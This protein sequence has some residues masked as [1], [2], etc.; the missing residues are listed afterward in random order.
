MPLLINFPLKTPD[1]WRQTTWWKNEVNGQYY[2]P[3]RGSGESGTYYLQQV[4]TWD[5][6]QKTA[7]MDDLGV[8]QQRGRQARGSGGPIPN[9]PNWEWYAMEGEKLNDSNNPTGEPRPRYPIWDALDGMVTT[10]NSFWS[11]GGAWE[12]YED[13]TPRNTN[14]GILTRLCLQQ[15]IEDDFGPLPTLVTNEQLNPAFQKYVWPFVKQREANTTTAHDIYLAIM[16]M[17]D[18]E[19]GSGVFMNWELLRNAAD[20]HPL[21]VPS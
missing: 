4:G 3:A 19:D 20:S 15:Y 11:D 12:F 7:F 5:T 21:T 14:L 6:D 2:P 18:D 17:K 1:L 8:I 13:T 9:G 16:H 10:A